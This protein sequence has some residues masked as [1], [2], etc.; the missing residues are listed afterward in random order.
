MF[1][2]KKFNSFI[3]SRDNYGTDVS[4]NFSGNS[5]KHKSWCGGISYII[6]LLLLLTFALFKGILMLQR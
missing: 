5:S 2:F 1:I 4:L 3:R 6:F